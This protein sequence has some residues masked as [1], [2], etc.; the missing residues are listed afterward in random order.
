MFV[1][2]GCYYVHRDQKY[3]GGG[4]WRLCLQ[5]AKGVTLNS[6][7]PHSSTQTVS[8]VS[9]MLCPSV[10]LWYLSTYMVAS[11]A[12]HFLEDG[13]TGLIHFFG[14]QLTL[15][16]HHLTLGLCKKLCLY[17][18]SLTLGSFGSRNR[19]SHWAG[20][21][22]YGTFLCG[23]RWNINRICKVMNGMHVETNYV[24]GPCHSSGG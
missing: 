13:L 14:H 10:V 8:R 24:Q 5:K 21:K 1:I 15:I 7:L 20:N 11:C 22:R 16:L 12:Q 2:L 17:G 3:N 19:I 9:T 6:I 18:Q 4:F 23:K